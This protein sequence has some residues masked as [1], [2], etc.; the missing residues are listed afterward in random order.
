[1]SIEWGLNSQSG[2]SIALSK[3]PFILRNPFYIG[4]FRYKGEIHEGNMKP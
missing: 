3:I 4:L 1:M 2:K